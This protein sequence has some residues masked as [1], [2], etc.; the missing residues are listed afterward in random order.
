MA[1]E[2]NISAA[3]NVLVDL[4]VHAYMK[5]GAG[6]DVNPPITLIPI[7]SSRS[8][9]R[10]RGYRHSYLLARGLRDRLHEKSHPGVEVLELLKVNRKISDMS[11]LTKAERLE[12]VQGAYSM[13]RTPREEM[14]EGK[15][16]ILLDDVATTG[17]SINEAIRCLR[18]AKIQ[19]FGAISAGVSP[20]LI[21]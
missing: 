6:S 2:Q 16:V 18:E 14:A 21:S 1:K 9:N 11:A 5:L 7:P 8:A 10:T 13:T 17:S 4:L 3:R 12:N 20:L 15:S 19:P